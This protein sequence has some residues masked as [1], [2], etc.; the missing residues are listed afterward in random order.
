MSARLSI[1]ALLPVTA[2]LIALS[3]L[4]ARAQSYT[5]PAGIPPALAPGGLEGR[6]AVPNF[7]ASQ[8]RA[9]YAA[10][11]RIDAIVTGSLRTPYAV[12]RAPSRW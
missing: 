12:R 4:S 11:S 6:A 5:A 7:V 3:A 2:V 10:P 9:R 1:P 8:G